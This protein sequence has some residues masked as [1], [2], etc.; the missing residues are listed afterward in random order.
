MGLRRWYCSGKK[1]SFDEIRLNSL[2]SGTKHDQVEILQKRIV[3]Q[4][5]LWAVSR[6]DPWS[7]E[8]LTGFHG[9]SIYGCSCV[10][11]LRWSNTWD[12][13]NWE[14]WEQQN[15]LLR[16]SLFG[17]RLPQGPGNLNG[18]GTRWVT[19]QET[20]QVSDVWSPVRVS[21]EPGQNWLTL[22]RFCW[23]GEFLWNAVLPETFWAGA[24]SS[25]IFWRQRQ[26]VPLRFA[27]WVFWE[28]KKH[29]S[30]LLSPL[31]AFTLLKWCRGGRI[32]ELGSD[33][34]RM[35]AGYFDP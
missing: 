3:H 35:L 16:S 19:R 31:S 12:T 21:W 14:V 2:Q 20:Q 28:S 22:L 8:L 13:P 10:S 34:W 5:A 30:L 23:I 18:G 4:L 32:Q 27:A 33:K 11:S 7:A 6:A 15:P 1:F 26:H 25:A 17:S 9:L 29:S 24:V